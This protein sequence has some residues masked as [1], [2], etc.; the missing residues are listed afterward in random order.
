MGVADEPGQ[1]PRAAPSGTSGG[2]ETSQVRSHAPVLQVP[3]QHSWIGALKGHPPPTLRQ[4]LFF[5]TAAHDQM[6]VRQLRALRGGE[7]RRP[8]LVYNVRAELV[9]AVKGQP[10]RVQSGQQL[11]GWPPDELGERVL[12]PHDLPMTRRCSATAAPYP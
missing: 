9:D 10:D 8:Q 6:H 4:S 1:Q 3:S 2:E 7:K 12:L 5:R 11:S